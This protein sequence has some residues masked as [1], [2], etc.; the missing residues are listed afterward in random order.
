MSLEQDIGRLARTKPFDLLPR[1]ALKLIAF[2]A[3][4]KKFAAGGQI[5]D[6]GDEADCA[7]FIVSGAVELTAYGQGE[8]QQRIVTPGALI[9]EM[10]MFAPIKRPSG[11]RAKEDA[12][13][14]RISRD[15]MTRV[16][17]EYGREAAQIHAALADRTRRLATE[18]D[19]VRRRALIG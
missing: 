2:S 3:D 7:Y 8:P 13:A 16:L 6:Q 9:G 18:L 5:F 17:G 1:D 10:A 12:V 15:L 19:A 4:R 11:A 14:L